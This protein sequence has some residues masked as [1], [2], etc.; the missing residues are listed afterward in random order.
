MQTQITTKPTKWGDKGQALFNY[1]LF[2]DPLPQGDD[3]EQLK[4]M[5]AGQD[6][7]NHVYN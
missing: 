3:M 6:D 7:I 2:N 4:E 5:K 1:I